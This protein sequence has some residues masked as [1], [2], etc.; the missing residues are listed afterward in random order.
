MFL[1]PAEGYWA[2]SNGTEF[3]R[4]FVNIGKL[5]SEFELEVG[6]TDSHGHLISLL[7][8]VTTGITG[9]YEVAIFPA[10]MQHETKIL[11]F[12]GHRKLCLKQLF[13]KQC[14]D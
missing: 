7:S 10:S 2:S 14:L 3:V 8:F 5:L 1:L 6:H 13:E 9:S 12:A 4:N 11:K